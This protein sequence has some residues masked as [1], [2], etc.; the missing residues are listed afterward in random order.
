MIYLYIV[1]NF[2]EF[3]KIKFYNFNL[4]IKLNKQSLYLI[5][6]RYKVRSL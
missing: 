5:N 2:L 6:G 4:K 1:K 3:F